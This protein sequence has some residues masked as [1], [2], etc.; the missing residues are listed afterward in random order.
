MR[1]SIIIPALSLLIV[2]SCNDEN[3]QSP[4]SKLPA[5]TVEKTKIESADTPIYAIRI[6]PDVLL[7]LQQWD[8]TLQ[9][10]QYLGAPAKESTYKL[11]EHSD[12]F[13]GS[14]FRELE[15]PGLQI[16][17]FS[18]RQNGNTFWVQEIILTSPAYATSKDV[19]VGDSLGKVSQ[20]YNE[21]QKFPGVN[22]NMYYVADAGYEKSIEMEFSGGKLVKL[23][24]YYMMP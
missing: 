5:D 11:D 2:C 23:R 8:S 21:L 16:K 3:R 24:M 13:A 18:P 10:R 17:L 7:S 12:T 19:R 6:R 9:L 15:W 20:V 22:E 14:Y 4:A 1:G